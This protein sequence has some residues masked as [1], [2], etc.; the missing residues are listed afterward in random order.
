MSLS[1]D[2]TTNDRILLIIAVAP[3]HPTWHHSLQPKTFKF[4]FKTTTN[5]LCRSQWS[6]GLRCWSAAAHL[7]RLWVQIPQVAWMFVCCDC[8][9]LS[10]RGL[11]K[12]L[13]THPEESYWMWCVVVCDLETSWMR[14]PWPTVGCRAKNKLISYII[15]NHYTQPPHNTKIWCIVL[16]KVTEN[17][18]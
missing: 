18:R 10:G 4:A 5:K 15:L 17:V 2:N 12:E 7:L 1:I 9:V 16:I 6:R 8:C 3:E 11:C 13:I 14:R